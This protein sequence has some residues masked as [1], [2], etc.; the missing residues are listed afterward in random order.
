[1]KSKS[2]INI[3][4]FNFKLKCIM[5]IEAN[6]S[7]PRKGFTISD[8][9]I[10]L[11][12]CINNQFKYIYIAKGEEAAQFLHRFGII[13]SYA[14]VKDEVKM[15]QKSLITITGAKGEPIQQVRFIYLPWD[16]INISDAAI[17]GIAA[18]HEYEAKGKVMGIVI[19]M[20]NPKKVA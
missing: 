19:D 17:Q 1:M 4:P 8:K 20:I 5:D 16:D 14:I 12:Y 3:L 18:I 10:R 6:I 9:G 2:L 13:D 15:Y 7:I 11:C